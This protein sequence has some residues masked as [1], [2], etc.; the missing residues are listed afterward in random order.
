MTTHPAIGRRRA[1]GLLLAAGLLLAGC[2]GQGRPGGGEPTAPTDEALVA[3]PDRG[4]W[5]A[6]V[7][8]APV[9]VQAAYAFAATEPEV[10]RWQPCHCGCGEADGHRSNLDCFVRERRADGGVVLDAHGFAC[11]TCVQIAR[12]A[13]RLHAEGRTVRQIR[14]AID[15]RYAV[16]GGG[17]PTPLP[18]D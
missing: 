12:E 9:G 8:A 7:Q 14:D 10:L 6:P 1:L 18:P 13:A 15:A 2:G 11:G 5:P 3:W 17:T 4:R 16:L